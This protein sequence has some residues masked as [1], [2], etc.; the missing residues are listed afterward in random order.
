MAEVAVLLVRHLVTYGLGSIRSFVGAGFGRDPVSTARRRA[1]QVRRLL[2]DLG[3]TAVKIGQI[4]S[5][6]PDL[7]GPEYEAE[8]SK[9]QDAARPEPV[10]TVER[11]IEAELGRPADG[12]FATF[13]PVPLAAASIGQAHAATWPD[14]TQVVVKVRRPG[15]VRDVELD[16]DI[17]DWLSATMER[18]S[19]AA[20]R[21]GL[22]ALIREFSATL[23]AELDYRKEASNADRF[24]VAFADDATVRIPHV[25]REAT[26]S[27]VITLERLRGLKI[28][29]LAG[30]DAAGIDRVLLAR[31]AADA[32][33]KMVFEHGF[34]HADPHPGNF[35]VEPDGRI[36]LIDFGMVGTM[37]PVTRA[38]LL[39]VL[40]ALAGHDTA[41]LADAVTSLGMTN[42]AL[43][44]PVLLA[45]LEHLVG[46]H[47][48]QPLGEIRLGPLLEDILAVLRRH[49]LRLPRN[50]ALL[51]K[52]F[53]MCEG[54]A[55]QLDPTFRM[56]AAIVPYVQGLGPPG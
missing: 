32:I 11:V 39:G 2:E 26:T 28:D 10:S 42:Q 38:A 52:T 34:F 15:V 46:A 25:Y 41:R 27:R 35:F 53:A 45:D 24:A 23:R 13:D 7:L 56:T 43:D 30:L 12:V 54:V 50:L 31:H 49:Q 33:L 22:V 4:L 9:L 55:A 48:E 5:T 21:Q 18:W 1:V 29:D 44:E 40:L 51:A 6:R 8:L 36:G 14:G 47:L 3:V 20:R 19:R 37:D 17:L 16:L